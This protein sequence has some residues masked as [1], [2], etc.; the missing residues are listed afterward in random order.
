MSE[1][2]AK[3]P[4][5]EYGIDSSSVRVIDTPKMAVLAVQITALQ[6]QYDALKAIEQKREF[7]HFKEKLRDNGYTKIYGR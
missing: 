2:N 1:Y 6:A 7:A 5:K 3:K 4:L